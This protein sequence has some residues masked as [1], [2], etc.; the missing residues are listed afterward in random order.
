[1]LARQALQLIL[2]PNPTTHEHAKKLHKPMTQT[3]NRRT[4]RALTR[5]ARSSALRATGKPQ[6]QRGSI[7][8]ELKGESVR[9]GVGGAELTCSGRG[10]GRVEVGDIVGFVLAVHRLFGQA[11][12]ALDSELIA[13][14]SERRKRGRGSWAAGEEREMR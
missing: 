5:P 12:L 7:G 14:A 2:Q 4:L 3:P 9:C 1:M 11:R 13:A 10:E 8:S 6:I